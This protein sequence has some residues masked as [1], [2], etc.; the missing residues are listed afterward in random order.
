MAGVRLRVDVD[1]DVVRRRLEELG[2][3]RIPRLAWAEIGQTLVASTLDRFESGRGPDDVPWRPSRRAREEGGQTLVDTSRLRD[4]IHHRASDDGVEI[5]TNVVYA[6]I[7]QLG[8]RDDGS[9]PRGIPARPYLGVDDG[10]RAAI[11]RIVERS[12]ASELRA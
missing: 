10:D 3:L 11:R 7:H 4:S 6:A 12:V 5:G 8:S 1:D 9:R 2:A